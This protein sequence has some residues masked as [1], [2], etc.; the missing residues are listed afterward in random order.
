[1]SGHGEEH[2]NESHGE[3]GGHDEAGHEE[4][5]EEVHEGHEEHGHP[6]KH[7]P[8]EE[9]K[10]APAGK[11]T[12]PKGKSITESEVLI[13]LLLAICGRV[14]LKVTPLVNIPSVEPIIPLAVF[15]GMAYGAGPGTLVGLLA[16]PISNMLIPEV[17]FDMWSFW[18]AA[19]GAVAGGIAGFAKKIDMNTLLWYTFIGTLLFEVCVNFP[20]Q[21]IL[22]WPFSFYHIFSNLFFAL[23]IGSF[24]IKEK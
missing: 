24:A 16:Y 3:N 12:G 2:G 9:K 6:E 5:H 23:V 4:S 19:G 10:E 8:K 18:Q 20:D 17:Q 7:E 22:V 21:L 11:K 15:A 1:M 13:I 14:L